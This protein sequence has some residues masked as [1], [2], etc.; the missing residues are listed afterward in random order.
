[1]KPKVLYPY[2]F[3]DTDTTRIVELLRD[4]PEVELRIRRMK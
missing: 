4:V 2:H 3:G 1:M